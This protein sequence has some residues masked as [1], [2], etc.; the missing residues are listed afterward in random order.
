MPD[1]LTSPKWGLWVQPDGPNGDKYFL[2]CHDVDDITE[3]GGASNLIRCF[4]ADG[5]GWDIIGTTKDPP[6]PVDITITAPLYETAD[7]LETVRCPA[8]LYLTGSLCGRTDLFAAYKRAFALNLAEATDK[9]LM[10]LAKREESVE[11]MQSFTYS[12]RPPVH[13]LFEMSIARLTTTET[14]ALNDIVFCNAAKC[15]DS[16]GAAEDICED[17]YA[18]GDAAAGSPTNTADVIATTD[19]GATWAATAADP[20]AGGEDIISVQCFD[21][22]SETTRILV[23]R[24]ADGAAAMEVAY[25]DDA[26]ATWT[27]VTVGATVGQGANY[28]GALLALDMN[29]I[30]LVTD[31][32]Y[33]YFS[34]DG[35]E[36]WETQDPGNATTDDLNAI[37]ALSSD[38]LMA[39]GD[40]DAVIFTE[41][42]GDTWV[43]VTATGGG[44]NLLTVEANP[45]GIW[46]IG[47]DS[48]ELYYSYDDGTTWTQRTGW[49]GSGTGTI[50]DIQFYNELC[51]FMTHNDGSSVGRILRTIDGGNEWF[52]IN[53]PTGVT[54]GGL[55][56]LHVCNCNLV[57]AVGEASGG[58]A[59]IYKASGGKN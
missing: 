56:A 46:W 15:A 24:E 7:W 52:R 57:Y 25:S 9:G 5:S 58:T 55:N 38:I 59:V 42:G 43:A 12:A 3:P 4:R 1:I 14:E 44:N 35:G 21:I 34:D 54:N 19:K 31:G 2:G 29:H 17:G 33:V 37:A 53:L 47:D 27:L 50:T 10:G 26:G 22:D 32:G 18:V 6:D 20:F 51:G 36:S 41:D 16:C 8:T 39:V 48:A 28:G 11:S 13:R 30:W 49:L 45:Y 40:S 23:A